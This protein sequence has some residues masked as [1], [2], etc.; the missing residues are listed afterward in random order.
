MAQLLYPRD[1]SQKH[2]SATR[3]QLRLCKQGKNAQALTKHITP[4]YELLS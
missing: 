1:S 2:M 4:A 3:R